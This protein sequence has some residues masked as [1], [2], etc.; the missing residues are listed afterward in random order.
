M[1]RLIR[2]ILWLAALVLMI[3][4]SLLM[5][6]RQQ[7]PDNRI[8]YLMA[9]TSTPN[10]WRIYWHVVGT[11]FLRLMTPAFNEIVVAEAAE[12]DEWIIF[13]G[14]L[15]SISQDR[16]LY[17]V[18]SDST[19]FEPIFPDL[20]VWELIKPPG[21][22][23]SLVRT[24]KQVYRI[25]ADGDALI[26]IVERDNQRASNYYHYWPFGGWMVFIDEFEAGYVTY[27]VRQTDGLTQS[28]PFQF[29]SDLRRRAIVRGWVGQGDGWM[30]LEIDD[31]LYQMRPDGSEFRRIVPNDAPE[32][33]QGLGGLDIDGWVAVYTRNETTYLNTTRLVNLD[34]PYPEWVHEY[35][36]IAMDDQFMPIG[37]DILLNRNVFGLSLLVLGEQE[38]TQTPLLRK[39]FIG[40]A[41]LSPDKAWVYFQHYI[42]D[43]AGSRFYRM[44]SDG[45][46]LTPLVFL[47]PFTPAPFLSGDRQWAVTW[48]YGW[49][50]NLVYL[51]SG[52]VEDSELRPL[53]TEFTDVE[54]AGWGTIL[55]RAW[56][57][58]MLFLSALS[59]IL[60]ISF[61]PKV[62][63]RFR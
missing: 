45:T 62:Y 15:G 44:R 60:I 6:Y 22:N 23:W 63:T 50:S 24:P 4:T 58:K 32:D 34:R 13:R 54:F 48:N 1:F 30:I 19:E 55:D 28:S 31:K 43:N 52:N 27:R 25:N 8:A 36:E 10:S 37:P 42:P 40:P 49:P 11:D 16:L 35:K 7:P 46:D 12:G 18:R 59:V 9:N 20:N 56:S 2:L 53:P 57:P 61:A 17:R 29:E 39:E 5:V 47:P 14:Y 41:L 3:F 21:S 51:L 38:I 33:I 26:K